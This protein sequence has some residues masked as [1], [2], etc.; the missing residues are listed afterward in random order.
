MLKRKLRKLGAALAKVFDDAIL[1]AG[2]V[3]I[4]LAAYLAWPP[5]GVAVLGVEFTAIG[6]GLSGLKPRPRR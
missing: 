6:L 4:A 1:G 3:L 5:A 2:L